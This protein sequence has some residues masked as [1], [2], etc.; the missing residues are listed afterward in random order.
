MNL[1]RDY[2]VK[3]GSKV[4]LARIHP[5]DDGG[6]DRDKVQA[7]IDRNVG[8]LDDLQYLLYAEN[9]HA[10]LIV[11][12]AMDAAGKDG[13][14]RHVMTGFSPEGCHVT[15][16]KAPSEEELEHDFLWRVHK[17]TPRKGEVAIFNRSHYEDVLVVR[18]KNLAPREVWM[19]RYGE[20]NAFEKHL[21]DNG[22]VIVK[23]FL[24]ISKDE[25]KE[26]LQARLDD[27]VK[28]FKFNPGDLAERKNW[29]RYAAAYEDALSKCS[30]PWAPWYVIPANRKWYR[31]LVVSEILVKTLE[32]LDMKLPQITFDP[33]KIKIV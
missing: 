14:I 12:Q 16:F 24:H 31:N 6:F 7:H 22:T 9:K 21:A 20:I 33:K 32:R 5:G 18:V 23:L 11:L 1:I 27:P 3:P 26:R 10:L 2:L 28:R 29:D 13:T 25:Q 8:R 30:T 4:R 15:S 19:R 17:V